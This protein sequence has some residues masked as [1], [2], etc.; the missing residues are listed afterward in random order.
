MAHL[1][2]DFDS[3]LTFYVGRGGEERERDGD[4]GGVMVMSYHVIYTCTLHIYTVHVLLI[5][6]KWDMNP[7]NFLGFGLEV[8][9]TYAPS[10][11]HHGLVHL[12]D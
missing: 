6:K 5:V 1:L 12:V 2:S 7:S 3:G 10:M 9:V 8:I 4:D 11:L